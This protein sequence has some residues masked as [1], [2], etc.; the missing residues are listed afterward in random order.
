MKRIIRVLDSSGDSKVEFDDKLETVADHAAKD[1]AKALFE[2]MTRAGAIAFNV[3]PGSSA[4]AEP[5]KSFAKI[6][7]ET[8]IVPKIVGG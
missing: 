1:E 2:R 3:T 6:G 8:V 4:P 5:V 7:E